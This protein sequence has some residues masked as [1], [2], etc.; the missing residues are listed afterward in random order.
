MSAQLGPLYHWSP[1]DRRASI[2]RLGLVPGRRNFHGPVFNGPGVDENGEDIVVPGE[3][4]A[5]YV[6]LGTTPVRAWKY[7]HGAWKSTGTFDLWSATL[8]DS[9]EVHV[10]PFW[11][12]RI[13]E[14]RVHNRIPKSRLIWVGERTVQ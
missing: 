4:R 5:N 7:S 2:L 6:C 1:R 13:I 10:N 11:G 14:V 3:W 9:D 12:D 8:E